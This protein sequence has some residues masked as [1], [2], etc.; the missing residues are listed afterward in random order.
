MFRCYRAVY[1]ASVRGTVEHVY[2]ASL[3]ISGLKGASPAAPVIFRGGAIAIITDLWHN[4]TVSAVLV[5]GHV[6]AREAAVLAP[7]PF[8]IVAGP[9]LLGRVVD[10]LGR[11]LDGLGCIDH[12][13]ATAAWN[14][15]EL[16]PPPQR[17]VPLL[18]GVESAHITERASV[19]AA[20]P[21]GRPLFDAFSPLVRG[22]CA[23]IVGSS[24]SLATE[25]ALRTV[26]AVA[27]VNAA[28]AARRRTGW[29]S[30]DEDDAVP[31]TRCVYVCIGSSLAVQ[32]GIVRSLRS[33][34]AMAWTTVIAAPMAH[35]WDTTPSSSASSAASLAVGASYLAPYAGAAIAEHWARCGGHTLV[36]YDD[37]GDHTHAARA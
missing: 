10:P 29:V 9:G 19:R 30:D 33:S 34:G 37:L 13:A 24:H 27:A 7:A 35:A 1:P 31:P 28:R 22:S 36:V 32:R 26:R 2:G 11:P 21:C 25:H 12:V 23:A 6:E 18:R 14:P 17:A 20:L 15:L 3:R 8:D 4:D 5:S 16:A